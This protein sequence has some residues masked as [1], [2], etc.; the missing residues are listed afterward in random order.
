MPIYEITAP[1]GKVFE[2]EGDSPPTEQ[3]LNQIYKNIPSS[4]PS[5]VRNGIP[6]YGNLPPVP[7]SNE[8]P[9]NVTNLIQDYNA[10]NDPY[11]PQQEYIDEAKN[12]V[13]KIDQLNAEYAPLATE[14]VDNVPKNARMLNG[15]VSYIEDG[16]KGLLSGLTTIPRFLINAYEDKLMP[17][18]ERAA[19]KA[20]G[21]EGEKTNYTDVLGLKPL[22]QAGDLVQNAQYK[23]KTLIGQIADFGGGLVPYT[24][25]GGGGLL[26]NALQ[27]GLA[28]LTEGG[29]LK[30]AAIGSL[31]GITMPPLIKGLGGTAYRI[32]K[33][34]LQGLPTGLLKNA[35]LDKSTFNRLVESNA[36]ILNNVEE[37]ASQA[38]LNRIAANL[39]NNVGLLKNKE[40]EALANAKRTAFD[41][42]KSSGASPNKTLKSSS[43][44]KNAIKQLENARVLGTDVATRNVG[45]SVSGDLLNILRT[46]SK[47]PNLYIDDLQFLKSNELDK[48][49]DYRPGIGQNL[50]QGERNV[51]NIAKKLRL[52]TNRALQSMLGSEYAQA[53]KKTYE[54]NRLLENTDLKAL[55]NGESTDRTASALQSL[56][57][58]SKGERNAQLKSLIDILNSEGIKTNTVDDLLDFVAAKNI[59]ARINTGNMGG[60]SNLIRGS[61]IN[62]ALKELVL[63]VARNPVYKPVSTA[64]RYSLLGTEK[65]ADILTNSYAY[66]AYSQLQLQP[67]RSQPNRR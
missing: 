39:R 59:D 46:Y 13:G 22:V 35:G 2:I 16:G 9:D 20:T 45:G 49:I 52:R 32:T 61:L 27:G 7:V 10:K 60:L 51:Q 5:P 11:A 17:L 19:R 66:P 36:D 64:G 24:V 21:Y 42:L 25:T 14:V 63:P 47:K 8:T 31:A 12:L 3:E 23:P 67:Q 38:N 53:N 30:D 37:L 55:V 56:L 34:A 65:L 62:P 57:N 48:I 40:L 1:N 6:V 28:G 50:S 41:N 33:G 54:L 58:Y 18:A 26:L 44:F 43:L 29:T 4:K 15:N